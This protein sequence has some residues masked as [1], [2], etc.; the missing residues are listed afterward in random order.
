MPDSIQF[1]VI[2]VG[3][4]TAEAASTK[5][6]SI[7]NAV[8]GGAD[9]EALAKK[10]G[11]TG[12]KTWLTGAQYEHSATMDKDSKS[13][14]STVTTLGVGQTANVKL[15]SGNVIVQV[16]D[17]KAMTDKYVA[18]VVKHTIDFSYDTYPQ[19]SYNF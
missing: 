13:Y 19:V 3:A 18:A 11:Q 6:D 7:Y 15:T 2:Q 5:A 4:E 8:N 12:E 14:L 9:F 10:Y 1:R 16:L 17:R